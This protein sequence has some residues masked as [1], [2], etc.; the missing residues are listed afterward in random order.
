MGLVN[1]LKV[2]TGRK[3]SDKQMKRCKEGYSKPILD[4]IKSW[5]SERVHGLGKLFVIKKHRH[6]DLTRTTHMDKKLFDSRGLLV[7]RVT[8]GPGFHQDTYYEPAGRFIGEF[9]ERDLK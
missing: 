2:A 6:S 5:G 1:R 3:L 4:G 8:Y 7:H 9:V